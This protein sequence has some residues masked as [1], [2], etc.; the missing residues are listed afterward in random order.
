MCF[1]FIA[2]TLILTVIPLFVV[3]GTLL[4][5]IQDKLWSERVDSI[6]RHSSFLASQMIKLGYFDGENE[7]IINNLITQL[8]SIYDGRVIVVDENF[9]VL[10]DSYSRINDRK[11]ISPEVVACMDGQETEPFYD[12]TYDMVETVVPVTDSENVVRGVIII[13]ASTLDLTQTYQSIE[14][15]SLWIAIGFS[16]ILAALSVLIGR[17]FTKPFKNVASSIN[18]IYEGYF[19]EEIHLKGYSEIETISDAFNAM[20]KR[21]K[22]LEDSRQE[23]VSNVSHELKTPLTSMKVLAESLNS[24]PDTPL[25]LYKEFMQDIA[26]EIDREDAII[27]DLL[28]LVKM[29]KKAGDL[30]VSNVNI[31]DMLEL[32]LKRL[33]PVAAK[34]GIELVLES[35]RTVTADCDEMKL[36]LAFTNLVENAIK[37]NI[38]GGWV[39]VSLDADHKFFYVKVS[40][41]GIG[42]PEELQDKIFERFFRVDKARSRETGGTGLGLAI[43]KN[44]I[45]MHDGAIK[46]KSKEDEGTTFTVRI[47]LTVES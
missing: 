14:R 17:A 23:F 43:T 22:E 3:R 13:D 25:E 45:M 34:R 12:K 37:Y 15:M 35:F 38:A 11:V 46:V 6:E 30:N 4:M 8:D 32:I 5:N 40:D 41:S 29:D 27:N 31:N 24:Q 21:L 10:R 1:R 7:N 19:D 47:P 39:Q 20:L 26:V 2:I 9:T 44:I 42:I 28:S 36:T 33:R 16:V 18:R